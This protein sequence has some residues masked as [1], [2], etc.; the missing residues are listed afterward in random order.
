MAHKHE[1]LKNSLMIALQKEYLKQ[2]ELQA[3]Q[4]F[5]KRVYIMRWVNGK[6]KYFGPYKVG[7]PGTPDIIGDY[8][9][10]KFVIEVKREGDRIRP[11]Q[12]AYMERAKERGC[13]VFVCKDNLNVLYDFRKWANE[14]DLLKS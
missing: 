12:K 13:G 8:K 5:G 1:T 6:K 11:E 4:N 7:T 9:G 14:K 2:I 3:T 10:F